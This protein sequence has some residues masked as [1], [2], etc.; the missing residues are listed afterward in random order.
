VAVI[1]AKRP[2][3]CNSR[4]ARSYT[5][6]PL[7]G[8]RNRTKATSNGEGPRL[9]SSGRSSRPGGQT[10]Q[11]ANQRPETQRPKAGGWHSGLR[12][13]VPGQAHNLCVQLVAC[14]LQVATRYSQLAKRKR[15]AATSRSTEHRVHKPQ[16]RAAVAAAG[17]RFPVAVAVAGCGCGQRPAVHCALQR[18]LLSCF[19]FGFGLLRAS[20][21]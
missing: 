11:A 9:L 20:G 17:C 10:G 1:N 15:K 5:S 6:T 4:L 8:R 19:G 7:V 18:P 2:L 12:P 14:S 13:Q 21:L 3:A 16:S